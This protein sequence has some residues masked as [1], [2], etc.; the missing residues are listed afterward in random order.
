MTTPNSP[1]KDLVQPEIVSVSKPNTREV[2]AALRALL[3]REPLSD[4]TD[5]SLIAEAMAFVEVP[6][7]DYAAIKKHGE[8]IGIVLSGYL[9]QG[10]ES[11]PEIDALHKYYQ[12]L[13]CRNRMDFVR[14]ELQQ[15]APDQEAIRS[16]VR[17]AR[18]YAKA[19]KE[20]GDGTLLEEV[21]ELI[22]SN[23]LQI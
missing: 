18:M 12:I 2:T 16:Q 10:M 21:E 17:M 22:G 13:L 20:Y 6:T 5:E 1:E 15:G 4:A 19:V 9:Q 23:H 14:A 3:Q 11:P 7:D 8:N